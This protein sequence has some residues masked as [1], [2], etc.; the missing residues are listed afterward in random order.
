VLRDAKREPEA[1]KTLAAINA[2]GKKLLEAKAKLKRL[3]AKTTDEKAP[4]LAAA[5][6][7]RKEAE[8][9]AQP[10]STMPTGPH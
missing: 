5:V 10:K 3:Q 8:P 6:E 2:A 1:A 9:G 4:S 7:P